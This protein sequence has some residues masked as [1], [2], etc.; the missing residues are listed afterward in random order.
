MGSSLDPARPLD[1]AGA[2]ELAVVERDGVIESRHLGAAVL[3]DGDGGIVEALGDPAALIYPRSAAK[4]LQATA[5]LGMGVRLEGEE[6]VLA[7]A[8]HAGTPAHVAI[9]ERMLAAAGLDEGALRC[10]ADWPL[11]SDARTAAA[12][13]R[14]IAMN[15]SGKHAAFL[16]AAVHGGWSTEDYLDPAHPVQAAVAAT[17][18][19][20]AGEPVAHWGVDGCLAPTPV[21]SLAGL[22]RSFSRVVTSGSPLPAAMRAHPWA[23]DGPGRENAV[24]IGLAGVLAKV[25]AEGVLVLATDDGHAVAV[26]TLDGAGRAR[27]PVGLELL[28]R[29]GLLERDRADAVVASVGD[30]G[31]RVAF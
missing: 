30:P 15:C 26:K 14:R 23:V 25:G 10:P 22:A 17:V 18:A 9:V 27:T 29:A 7:A 31:I 13:R 20:L 2:V 24:T 1:L 8:S 5:V 19:E 28:V 16:A 21:L 6:L 4:P 12:G 11:D 3:V